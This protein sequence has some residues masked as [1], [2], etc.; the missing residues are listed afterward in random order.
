MMAM[1]EKGVRGKYA[2]VERLKELEDGSVEWR[3][4]T[5]TT[6]GGFVPDWVTSKAVPAAIAEDVQQFLA[7]FEQRKQSQPAATSPRSK[8]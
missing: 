6:V 7:W 5:T 1:E 4:A 3:V 2:A 8:P